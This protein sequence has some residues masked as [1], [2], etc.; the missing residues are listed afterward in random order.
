MPYQGSQEL[1]FVLS[2]KVEHLILKG[3]KLLI[4]IIW[5]LFALLFK[6]LPDVKIQWRTVWIG[7]GITA[8]LFVL[9]KFGLGFY[10]GHSNP[11]STYGAAGSIILVL[12]WVS[13]SC[14]ILFFGAEF[15]AVFAK[16]YGGGI[17]P[18]DH[19]VRVKTIETTEGA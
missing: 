13:Y 16:R 8:V 6:Y 4:G 10:F 15:T 18:S 1:L 14:L 5:L 11:G 2:P 7:A 17:Q 3:L 9:G 19:A 12:L